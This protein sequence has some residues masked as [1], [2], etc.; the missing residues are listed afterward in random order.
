MHMT[1][2]FV[3]GLALVAAGCGGRATADDPSG[4]VDGGSEAGNEA[5]ADAPAP[6]GPAEAAPDAP[7]SDAPGPD[8][9]DASSCICPAGQVFRDHQCV[10]ALEVGC[11]EPCD[12]GSDDCLDGQTCDPCAAASSCSDDD[13]QPACV[14]SELSMGPVPEPLRIRP[15]VGPAGAETEIEVY[16]YP[17]HIGALF[18]VMRIDGQETSEIGHGSCALKYMTSAHPPG[19]HAVWLSQYGGNE[20]YVLAGFYTYSSGDIP[21]CVQPGLFCQ[22]AA[23][24]CQTPEVPMTCSGGRCVR[25]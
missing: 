21:S 19:M 7:L 2:L 16:G 3:A 23:D 8:V 25:P 17:F 4:S 20:P 13:C 22:S 9:A 14:W 5:S 18:Y 24:C 11:T 1:R 12:P 15:T 6:D 10:S